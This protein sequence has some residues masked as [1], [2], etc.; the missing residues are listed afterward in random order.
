[1][2]LR[3]Q[4]LFRHLHVKRNPAGRPLMPATTRVVAHFLGKRKRIETF[5]LHISK[6]LPDIMMWNL[7]ILALRVMHL[8]VDKLYK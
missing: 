4:S 5:V 8:T 6:D 7:A 1:M 2:L 3:R